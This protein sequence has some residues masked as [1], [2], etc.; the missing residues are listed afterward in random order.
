MKNEELRMGRSRPIFP[1]SILHSSFFILHFFF[2]LWMDIMFLTLRR[3]A[4]LGAL[5]VAAASLLLLSATGIT[6]QGAKYTIKT[7]KVDIPKELKPAVAVLFAPE[8]VHLLDGSGAVV[9]DV[10]LRKEVPADATPEQLKNGLT[11]REL[12]ETSV[13][14]AVRFHQAWT[15]YRKQKVKP[16]VY[17]LRLAFQPEDGD[18]AGSSMF[19]EFCLLVAAD[20]DIKPEAVEP[21]AAHEMSMKSIDTGHPAVFMLFPVPKA[22]A[23]PQLE[24]KENNH[25]VLNARENVLVNGQKG[26][27]GVGLTLVGHAPE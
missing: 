1:F 4:M 3:L 11:Y 7:G 12:K 15:D 8:A 26:V 21:K 22:P 27:I 5:A 24:A 18:H 16:G 13:L 25:W 23:A 20:K 17:T 9:C 19:K 2:F 10:W 6:A 14:G